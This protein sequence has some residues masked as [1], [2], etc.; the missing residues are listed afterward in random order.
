MAVAYTYKV[1]GVHTH[2]CQENNYLYEK[3]VVKVENWMLRNC[4]VTRLIVVPLCVAVGPAATVTDPSA[5]I[6][7]KCIKFSSRPR[8]ILFF[9]Q[10]LFSVIFSVL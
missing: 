9:V 10:C 6:C 4:R 2:P 1:L 3:T 5:L 8:P 7:I